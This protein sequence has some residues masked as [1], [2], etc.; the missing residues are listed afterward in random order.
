[1]SKVSMSTLS[2]RFGQRRRNKTASWL[3]ADWNWPSRGWMRPELGGM[4][5]RK[6]ES[7]ASVRWTPKKRRAA[8]SSSVELPYCCSIQVGCVQS[9]DASEVTE[10]VGTVGLK[11]CSSIQ[12]DCTQPWDSST[13]LETVA[14]PSNALG[15]AVSW[16]PLAPRI[17]TIIDPREESCLVVCY[18]SPVSRSP[19]LFRQ[20]NTHTIVAE[21][22]QPGLE[23]T[24]FK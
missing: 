21:K 6:S 3:R 9:G 5:V 13:A 19:V 12:V 4:L 16:E 15:D 2:S 1:M 24:Q 11:C 7:S 8:T 17:S 20:W 18:N 22:G 23:T 10:T 14:A